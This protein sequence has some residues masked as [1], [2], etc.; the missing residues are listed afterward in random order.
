MAVH[1]PFEYLSDDQEA[2]SNGENSPEVLTFR[3]DFTIVV[4]QIRPAVALRKP[5]PVCPWLTQP[6]QHPN[7][8]TENRICYIRL[9]YLVEV[10]FFLLGD[11]HSG[12]TLDK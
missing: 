12:L 5:N 3:K 6:R 11:L 7:D 2:Q 10:F 1:I 4:L 9:L 8:E